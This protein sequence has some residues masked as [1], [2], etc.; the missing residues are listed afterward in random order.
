MKIRRI[1]EEQVYERLDEPFNPPKFGDPDDESEFEKEWWDAV[2]MI[3]L[4]LRKYG[5]E[6]DY[7]D[8]DFCLPEQ[9]STSRGIGIELTS[10]RMLRHDLIEEIVKCVESRISLFEIDLVLVTE[11][12]HYHIFVS[13][14]EVLF[15]CPDSIAQ[16]L[17]LE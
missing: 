8:A 14:H 4:I 3:G 9:I 1:S 16:R 13:K 6:S 15:W 17:G 7:G 12:M 11:E 10:K 5:M 2:E